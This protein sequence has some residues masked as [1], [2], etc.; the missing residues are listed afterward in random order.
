M[1]VGSVP[2]RPSHR[3]GLVAL[4]LL[5]LASFAC[6][7][8]APVA[9][10]S[11]AIA[12][13]RASG[14]P[15][16][17]TIAWTATPAD[18]A[19]REYRFS[20]ARDG[21]AP[22]IVRDFVTAP[23]FT[24]TPLDEGGYAIVVEARATGGSG[25]PGE[26]VSAAYT[27]ASRAAAGAPVIS[28]TAHPLVA[29]YSIPPCGAAA[30][31]V[32]FAAGS[33]PAGGLQTP[34]AACSP[35][36]STNVYLVGMR[37]ST[38]YAI[39]YSVTDG[40]TTRLGPID[41]WTSGAIPASVT[42]PAVTA[43][44]APTADSD[45]ATGIVYQAPLALG[46]DTTLA[47]LYATDLAGNVLWY[48]PY[49]SNI[50]AG[51]A[52]PLPG[53][54]TLALVDGPGEGLVRILDPVGNPVRETSLGRLNDGL[55]ALAA[56]TGQPLP[57]LRALHHEANLLPN[58]H[59]VV[60]GFT[61][62]LFPPGTQGSTSGLPVDLVG[63]AIVDL[64]PDLQVAWAWDAFAH[65][66]PGRGAILGEDCV[67][68]GCATPLQYADQ[69][70]GT[71]RDWLHSNAVSYSPTDGNLLLSIRHQDWI[72]KIDY[73]DAR[74]NG[75][76]LWRLGA[77]G[78]FA[79]AN[80]PAGDPFP[81]F[82]HQH[83]VELTADG[84]LLTFDDGDTRCNGQGPECHSRGQVYQLDEA[85]RRATLL[86]D[87]DMGN[88]SAALGWAQFLPNGNLSFV[89][90][91]QQEPAPAF[92]QVEEF[93][94]SGVAR[95]SVVESRPAQLYRAYRLTTMYD[96][97]CAPQYAP[98]VPVPNNGAATPLTLTAV[99]PGT[100][101]RDVPGAGGGSYAYPAGTT[102]AL[103]ALPQPG[104]LFLGWEID[105]TPRGFAAVLTLTLDSAHS[106][107]A[108][109]VVAPAFA[110]LAAASPAARLAVAQL[111]AR[112]I[113][114][115][116]GDGTFGPT[117]PALR[118]QMAAFLVRAMGWTGESAPNPF[119]DRG[120]VDDE[121]W[122]DIGILAGR[123]V[124]RGYG[125]GTFDTLGPVL[126]AQAIS[127]VAR[128]MVAAGRW[129]PQPD[130]PAHYSAVPISSGHRQDLATYVRYAGP[131]RGTVT[132]TDSF[133]S[134]DQPATRA[135]FAFV[136]WRA[137]ASDGGTDQPGSAGYVP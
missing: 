135:W 106:V 120:G 86:A 131:V 111:A 116:D 127:F 97:C 75:D 6:P 66:D 132:A 80:P 47:Q 128:A 112:G 16:G 73:R 117:D 43:P 56:R 42:I 100:V 40:T 103:S 21:G 129:Q 11:I 90:G 41:H 126:N 89:S 2:A 12:P 77:G 93:D 124:A 61:E 45:T 119:S 114:R 37:P 76:I 70:G 65:L 95:L 110:D 104:A 15:V 71:A 35:V 33:A 10:A 22:T 29:L 19:A 115:G 53:G 64:D 58:G 13:D 54:D 85:N 123:S 105:G 107:V 83:G 34:A 74:G 7:A 48:L 28:A 91:F 24:W 57:P 67:P 79:L 99:G 18:A 121:L 102:V 109:F 125:D 27:I 20:V 136:L 32:R 63:D 14:Q 17:T 46:D 3:F 52:R 59:I 55:V 96:G 26:T 25:A 50:A 38:T 62:R 49:S 78:D 31:R 69:A 30:V 82:S 98:G 118:A 23:T 101:A 72:L 60:L 87:A 1:F 81:W 36:A 130:D 133:D 108:R 9:A 39:Q 122:A 4:L 113:A 5:G 8:P 84:R 94:P 51:V 134:W 92:G 68:P 44:V 137:L 88:N